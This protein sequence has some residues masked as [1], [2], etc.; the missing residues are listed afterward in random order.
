MF[1]GI[2]L[3]HSVANMFLLPLGIVSGADVS[4]AE[5]VVKNFIPVTIGNAI[6]GA[7]IVAA[8]YS[9]QFGKLGGN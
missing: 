9:Y 5:T 2:G 3:E 4:V 1:V 7:I 8:G 6:A